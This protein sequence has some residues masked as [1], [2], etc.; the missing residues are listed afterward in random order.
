[1]LASLQHPYVG[2]CLQALEGLPMAP[3]VSPAPVETLVAP[4]AGRLPALVH[5]DVVMDFSL[6]RKKRKNSSPH[7]SF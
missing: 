3:L 2:W 7:L 4:C 5:E 1:M 6:L